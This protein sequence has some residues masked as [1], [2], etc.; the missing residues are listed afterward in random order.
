MAYPVD[1]V[2]LVLVYTDAAVQY[3]ELVPVILLYDEARC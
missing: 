1:D 3:V 2:S